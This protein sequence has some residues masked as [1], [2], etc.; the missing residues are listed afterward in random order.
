M[1]ATGCPSCTKLSAGTKKLE[2]RALVEGAKLHGRLVRFDFG[3]KIVDGDRVT[4]F[5]C[6]TVELALGHGGDS[7]G[8]SNTLAISHLD[9]SAGPLVTAQC[10]KWL[11]SLRR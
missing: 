7:L 8:I 4:L 10:G 2:E 11:A 3:E 1:I 9:S 5:L 6:H